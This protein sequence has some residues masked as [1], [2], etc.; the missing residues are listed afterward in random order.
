[1]WH[2]DDGGFIGTHGTTKVV[3]VGPIDYIIIITLLSTMLHP[4]IR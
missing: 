3:I 2:R 1:V 4:I